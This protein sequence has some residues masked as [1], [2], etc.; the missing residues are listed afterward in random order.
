VEV[1]AQGSTVT[2]GPEGQCD[3][4]QPSAC[5]RQELVKTSLEERA[6]DSAE[7]LDRRETGKERAQVSVDVSWPVLSYQE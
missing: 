5:R 3:S 1:P 6:G 7:R 2:H 4:G